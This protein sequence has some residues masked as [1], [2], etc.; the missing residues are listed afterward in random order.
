MIGLFTVVLNGTG[1]EAYNLANDQAE[2]RIGD[3]AELLCRLYPDRHLRVV[4]PPQLGKSGKQVPWNP[5]F[6][7]DSAKL[8]ALGWNPSTTAEAGFRRTIRFYGD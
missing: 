2:L 6:R 7:F 5:G 3:L 8:Q 4:R 1:G